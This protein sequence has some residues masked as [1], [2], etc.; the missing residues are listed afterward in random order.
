MVNKC[1]VLD[2][3]NPSSASWT[4]LIWGDEECVVKQARA[5]HKFQR[6]LWAGIEHYQ[7]GLPQAG[8]AQVV[9]R[10]TRNP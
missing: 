1:M 8:V 4:V 3:I 6:L 9:E 2:L 10:R 7:V 5:R